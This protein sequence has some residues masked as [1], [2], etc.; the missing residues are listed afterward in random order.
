MRYNQM[1]LLPLC[2]SIP[3]YLFLVPTGSQKSTTEAV[4][5][6]IPA[7]R[8]DAE[9]ERWRPASST[10]ACPAQGTGPLQRN[11]PP[12]GGPA[13]TSEAAVRFPG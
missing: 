10:V 3:R 2:P 5:P 13:R 12:V 8:V 7:W 11:L 6:S 9:N 4:C 1:P